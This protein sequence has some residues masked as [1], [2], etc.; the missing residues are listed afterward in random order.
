M[1]F[2]VLSTSNDARLRSSRCPES[3]LLRLFTECLS[4]Q[5]FKDALYTTR[6]FVIT[7]SALMNSKY[8][9]KPT[10]VYYF[11]KERTH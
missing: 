8:S 1:G 6:P 4:F 5:A 11:I 3:L 7:L 2:L 9:A 10:E